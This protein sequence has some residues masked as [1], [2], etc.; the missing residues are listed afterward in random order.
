MNVF[1]PLPVSEEEIVR[2]RKKWEDMWKGPTGPI[3]MMPNQMKHNR[4]IDEQNKV[5]FEYSDSARDGWHTLT[6]TICA[7]CNYLEI[8]P[9][10]AKS[11]FEEIFPKPIHYQTHRNRIK[12]SK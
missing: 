3:L 12:E 1:E 7:D 4:S 11:I 9:N 5:V 6:Q 8:R 10:A 2:L